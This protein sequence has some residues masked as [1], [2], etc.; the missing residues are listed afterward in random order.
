MEGVQ[1]ICETCHGHRFKDHVLQYTLGGKNIK[2][3]LDMTVK[4]ALHFFRRNEVVST[5]KTLSEVGLDYMI[6]GQSLNTLSG[7]ECQRIKLASELKRSGNI[8]VLD[9][10]TTGLHMS[11]IGNLLSILNRLV[12]NGSTETN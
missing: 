2:E 9:E 6:L 3:I 1:T 7:G 5:L 11:D 4:D 12:D 8:Y 10:P